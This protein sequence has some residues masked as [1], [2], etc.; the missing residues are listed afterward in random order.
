MKQVLVVLAVITA[1]CVF[2]HIRI[3]REKIDLNPAQRLYVAINKYAEQYNIP[4]YIAYN[5]AC[6]ETGYRGPHHNTYNHRQTS[7][8]GTLGAM[9]IMPQYASHY[10]GFKVSKAVLKDSIELN[11]EIS[12]K[13]LNEWYTRYKRWDKATGAYNTGRPIINKYAQRAVV[14]DFYVKRWIKPDS[15]PSV[16]DLLDEELFIKVDTTLIGS[17]E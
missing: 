6:L 12:M 7:S 11:V 17:T 2:A 10:A 1:V 9:Q 4:L 5:V 3:G 14:E 8:A 16:S 15:L 13:M